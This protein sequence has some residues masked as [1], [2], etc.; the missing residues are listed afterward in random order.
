MN[1]PINPRPL[2]RR[3]FLAGSG[4]L[5]LIGLLAAC[6]RESGSAGEAAELTGALS[7]LLGSHMTPVEDAAHDH[8]G[9]LDV[10]LTVE[11][12][13][14][15]DLRNVLTNAFMAR[16]SQWDGVF[17][18]AEVVR[19][20]SDRQW[21]TDISG[22]LEP[23]TQSEDFMVGTMTAAEDAGKYLAVPWNVGAPIMHWNKNLLEEVGLDPE[24]PAEWHAQQNSWDTFVEYAKELTTTINGQQVYGFTDAWADTAVLNTWGS[25]L[26]MHG[27]RWFDDDGQPAFN[28][29]AGREATEKLYDLL[30]T[31]QVVDPA[32]T[33]YT[34]VFDA[35]PSFLNG[36]RGIFFTYPFMAGV[37]N[38][39]EESE[40]VGANGY[41]PQPA[42]ETSAS[43]DGSEF[44]AIPTFSENQG[45]A[46]RFLEHLLSPEVQKQIAL[47]GWATTSTEANLDPEV[48]EQ[49]PVN[50]AVVQSYEYPVDFGFSP[51]AAMWKSI[52]ADQIHA[53]LT[54]STNIDAALDDAAAQIVSERS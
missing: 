2:N 6:G 39:P 18:T 37:A 48:L 3:H 49:Y 34:W 16:R 54:D 29:D 46:E 19:E 23:Y 8:A 26:Q 1:K 5:A 31:H 24:A 36:T 53:V 11:H 27:G 42:V 41:A 25:L 45:E 44:L 12:V 52:L 4:G 14:T 17:L 47:A 30:H 10:D 7:L 15:P 50:E 28:S 21:L 43:V 35:S 51:D 9:N 22:L 13:T 40:I 38:D 32:A 20:M 33:T